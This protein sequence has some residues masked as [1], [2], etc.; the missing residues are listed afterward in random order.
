MPG[1]PSILLSLLILMDIA[2]EIRDKLG[3][4]WIPEIYR[5]VRAG[6]TRSYRMEIPE[7]EN[8][9]DIQH[10]LLG[11]ELK[12]GKVR[13]SCPDLST[14]RFLRVFAR[15]GCR[16]VAIPYDITRIPA[17][18]DQL[19]CAWQKTLLLFEEAAAGKVPQVKGKMRAGLIKQVRGEVGEIG[20]GE[21]MPQFNTSTRQ[22]SR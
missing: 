10:T 19:E 1:I 5:G 6:R 16:D 20:A 4:E 14:A 3:P 17:L 7:R 11:I 12:V 22:R 13:L 21:M 18:A 8:R 2:A 9:A 15:I